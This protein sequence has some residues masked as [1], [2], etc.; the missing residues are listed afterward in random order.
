MANGQFNIMA[1]VPGEVQ[2]GMQFAQQAQLRPLQIQQQ[3]QATKLGGINV[4]QAERQG[5]DADELSMFTRNVNTALELESLPNEQKAA[6][7]QQKIASGEAQ[8][9]SMAE[10]RKALDLVNKGQFDVLSQGAQQLI[11]VGRQRGVIQPTQEQLQ[12]KQRPAGVV[13]FESMTE[14]LSPDQKKQAKLISLGLSPRA[15]GSAIQTISDQGIQ[16]QIGDASATIKQREKFGEM[17]GSS[18]AKAVDAG[19]EK[20][21]KIDAGIGNANRAISALRSGAG[22]GAVQK[23][24][25]SFKAASVELDNI[26]KSM[27]LDVIGSVTFGALSEGEL[28]LAK[29]VALPTGLETPELIDYLERR[30]TAQQKLRDYFNEQVQFLDQGGTIA[31]FLRKKEGAEAQQPEPNPA[32]P[33]DQQPAEVAPQ[34][35]IA[36]GT[37]IS[38]R[39]TGQRMQLVNGN[40]EAL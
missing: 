8:G 5:Q 10:S 2:R 29:E 19:F 39:S 9:R 4:Q 37:I 17:T 6:Y 14:G 25:P 33:I 38:N 32:E 1:D 36:E 18:R 12:Q 3:E 30:K 13:E 22:V 7:L 31:G 11:E 21:I 27:A 20:I 16:E 24:L 23:F 28:N 26:R 40:W 35:E 34:P 15:V